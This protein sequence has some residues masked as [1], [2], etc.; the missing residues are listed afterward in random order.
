MGL[1]F[2]KINNWGKERKNSVMT[3]QHCFVFSCLASTFSL[4]HP[5]CPGCCPSEA[6]GSQ[7]QGLGM[8]KWPYSHQIEMEAFCRKVMHPG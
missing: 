5:H 7:A 3:E 2:F 4:L 6:P 8:V 1:N